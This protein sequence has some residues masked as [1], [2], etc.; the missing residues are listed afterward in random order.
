MTARPLRTLVVVLVALLVAAAAP[1]GAQAPGAWSDAVDVSG[2]GDATQLTSLGYGARGDALVVWSARPGP[3]YGTAGLPA[4]S[5]TWRIGPRLPPRLAYVHAAPAVTLYGQTRAVL[6]GSQRGGLGPTLRYRMIAA[7]GRSDGTFGP[8][9]TLDS[10]VGGRSAPL[11]LSS[12]AVA[13]T[14]AGH[15]IAA[16]SLG[17]GRTSAIRL[18]ERPAGG[19]FRRVE[20]VSAKG[21][22]VPTVAIG[23]GGDRVV[24]W[25][26]NGFIEA[27]VRRAGGTWG[28]V[29]KVA[30]STH[31]P[32][33]LRAAIDANGRALLAWGAIDYHPGGSALRFDAGVRPRDGGWVHRVLQRYTASGFAFSGAQQRVWVLF[34]SAGRGFVAWHGYVEGRP[35]VEV[36]A[37]VAT[38]RFD[39]PAVV[40]GPDEPARPT[41]LA[42]GPQERVAVVWERQTGDVVVRSQIRVAVRRAGAGFGA[43]ETLP[44]Q[45][46]PASSICMPFDGHAAFAPGSGALLVG[47][48]QRDDGGFSV[49]AATRIA[50]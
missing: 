23:S 47:W 31:R 27:R 12:P 48:L 34:D 33:V 44:V 3:F 41:D 18:A 36:S 7:F 5:T 45:C 38:D 40:T 35:A 30:A 1:S 17:D 37:L 10:G 49:Q 8:P 26:R 25:Y 29:L 50:P 28:S 11:S 6:V 39:A 43:A 21:A 20:T 14:A 24:A 15:I 19:S 4:G 22:G 46:P 42:A 16:W 9:R 13:A 2:A 32:S